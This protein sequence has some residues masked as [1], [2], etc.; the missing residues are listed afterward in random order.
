[1]IDTSKQGGASSQALPVQLRRGL[2]ISER[3]LLLAALDVLAVAAAYV[4]AFNVRTAG[5][6]NAGVYI[7]R[8]GTV[9]VV[10]LWLAAAR[11]MDAYDLRT[12]SRVRPTLRV[13]MGALAITFVGLLLLFFVFPYRI[14]RPT[15]L[16]WLPLAGIAVTSVRLAYRHTLTSQRL[17][18]QVVLVAT[19]PVLER[20]WPDVRA[21]TRALY[22]V[23]HVVDPTKPTG[24]DRLL[25]L[26][27]SGAV[28]EVVVGVRDDVSKELFATLLACY[29]SG[30]TVRSLADVYE[31]ITGRVLLDQLGQSWLLSLPMRSETSRIYSSC[32]R[33]I[34]VLAAVVGLAVLGALLP[35][36]APLIKLED[37]G[38]LFHRQPRVGKYGHVFQLSKLRTMRTAG[39]GDTSWTERGDPRITRVGRVLRVL[40]LDELP[41]MWSILRGD[42]S[43][44]G[45]RPEQPHYV[46]SLR[47]QIELY[48]TRL[49]V[50]PGLTGWAQVNFGYGSGVDGARVKLSY[51][52]YYVKRQSVSL[53]LLI[54]GRTLLAVLSF[55]G[56]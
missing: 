23:R 5:L 15:T 51:D 41:Q 10:V 49:T 19:Q 28:N 31:E 6:R 38:P 36:V 46:E 56:R 16:I 48:S 18:H 45:P 21:H 54:L 22:H 27:R 35:V 44:I 8:S 1:M 30:L 50:R 40:H 11:V 20:I 42:M 39:S 55:G 43:I 12:A 7:P 25:S 14:T 32:K 24:A 17:A 29:D 37:H 26:A 3:R 47:S 34:D 13:V 33:T 53:D 52:L 4:L 2:L 9:I